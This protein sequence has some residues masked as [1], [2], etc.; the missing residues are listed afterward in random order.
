LAFRLGLCCG[1][2]SDDDDVDDGADGEE[3]VEAGGYDI[4]DDEVVDS[5]DE[6]GEDSVEDATEGGLDSGSL[7]GND[8]EADDVGYEGSSE[9]AE[10]VIENGSSGFVEPFTRRCMNVSLGNED[11]AGIASAEDRIDMDRDISLSDALTLKLLFL[12]VAT[13]LT[14]L[15]ATLTFPGGVPF[16]TAFLSASTVTACL[17]PTPTSLTNDPTLPVA[18]R[19]KSTFS[20]SGFKVSSDTFASPPRVITCTGGKARS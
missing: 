2:D 4:D 8:V 7:S 9:G 18:L 13:L 1:T 14:I 19:F 11:D 3:T 5:V 10:A 15:G 16:T 6:A 20:T 12:P 17:T